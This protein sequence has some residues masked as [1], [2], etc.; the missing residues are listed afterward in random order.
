MRLDLEQV[1]ARVRGFEPTE[2]ADPGA[3]VATVLRD[4]PEVLLIRRAEHPD[5]PWSGH[6]AFPGGRREAQD[7]SLVHTA[8]RETREE[9]GLDLDR[10]GELLGALDD[11][12]T[13]LN[14]LVV[15]PY[16]WRVGAIGELRPNHEVAAVEWVGLDSLR[17]GAR[18]TEHAF[19]YRGDEHRFP[20]YEVDHGVVWGLTFRMLQILFEVLRR[21]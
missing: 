11:V 1:A 17:S 7:G 10:R 19:V 4:G 20:A 14:A 9:L 6:M 2:L 5:D 16:V 12:P 21:G 15:R 8:A 18:D 13:H 3:A